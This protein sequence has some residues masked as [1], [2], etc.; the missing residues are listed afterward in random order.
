MKNTSD[1]SKNK[2]SYNLP[3]VRLAKLFRF[4]ADDLSANR[5]GFLTPRQSGSLPLWMV[6]WLPNAL[7]PKPKANNVQRVCGQLIFE[8][9]LHQVHGGRMQLNFRKLQVV[10]TDLSFGIT[11]EQAQAIQENTLYAV[12]FHQDSLALLSLERVKVCE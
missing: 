12:Y 1:S 2:T 11:V 7:K 9:T 8:Q 10:G 6:R 3:D 5:G 4:T